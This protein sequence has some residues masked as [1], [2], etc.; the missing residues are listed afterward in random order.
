MR[1]RVKLVV[2][3]LAAAITTVAVQAG[4]QSLAELA[5]QEEARRKAIKVPA[6]V[7]TNDNL[8]SVPAAPPAADAGSTPPTVDQ[9]PAVPAAEA[10]AEP[11]AA[12]AGPVKDEKYWRQR[13][14]AARAT[15][16]RSQILQ[17]ALQ[18]RINAL[19]ADFVSRDDPA[20]RAVIAADRQKALAELDRVKQEIVAAQQEIANTQEEARKAG[21]PAGWVR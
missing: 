6:K 15:L 5:K 13:M 10:Q 18:S 21:V 3:L 7:I 9:A 16:T 12:P 11:A 4:A 2:A 8:P 14:T 20:Q 1:A 17:D 19:A